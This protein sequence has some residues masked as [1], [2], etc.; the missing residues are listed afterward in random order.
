MWT[1]NDRRNPEDKNKLRGITLPRLQ[2]ILQ[3]N[4][5]QNNVVLVQKQTYGSMEQK[6]EPSQKTHTPTV[7]LPQR[8]EHTM[9]KRQSPLQ[10]VLGKLDSHMEINEIRT[11]PHTIHNNELKML[12]DLNPHIAP[13]K[14]QRKSQAKHSVP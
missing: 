13:C 3:S 10:V 7:H 4:S 12:K 5:H 8:K 6:T 9:G 1:I 11:H 14:F 2:A